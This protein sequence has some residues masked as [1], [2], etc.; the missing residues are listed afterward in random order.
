MQNL[1]ESSCTLASVVGS[2]LG[3]F[4]S[5]KAAMLTLGLALV[6]LLLFFLFLADIELSY[7]TTQAV[8]IMHI[9]CT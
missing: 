2:M 9:V 5:L 7:S 1:Q 6:C 4:L 8:E 3:G